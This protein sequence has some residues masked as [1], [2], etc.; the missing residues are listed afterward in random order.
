VSETIRI[1]DSV[2]PLKRVL[3]ELRKHPALTPLSEGT[4]IEMPAI[5]C[6]Q[7][8][9]SRVFWPPQWTCL[10]CDR[11]W[12]PGGDGASLDEVAPYDAEGERG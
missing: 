12:T 10:S 8:G 6:S 4:M 2:Q 9:P 1:P 11:T 7:D 3:A 5:D